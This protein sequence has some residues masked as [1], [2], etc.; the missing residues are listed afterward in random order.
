MTSGSSERV[1]RESIRY[2][3]GE[4]PPDRATGVS[5]SRVQAAAGVRGTRPHAANDPA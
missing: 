5:V 2:A 1:V 4:P 3:A